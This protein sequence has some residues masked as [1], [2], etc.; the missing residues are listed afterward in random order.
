MS[1]ALSCAVLSLTSRRDLARSRAS[2]RAAL[3]SSGSSWAADATITAAAPCFP[4][5]SIA[6]G[7]WLAQQLQRRQSALPGQT[8]AGRREDGARPAYPQAPPVL[9]PTSWEKE[10]RSRGLEDDVPCGGETAQA[11]KYSYIRS[12]WS[13]LYRVN[14][15]V[16][17]TEQD[18][19]SVRVLVPSV[20]VCCLLCTVLRNVKCLRCVNSTYC[21]MLRPPWD[22]HR[23]AP[24]P[25]ST[26]YEYSDE[27]F[28]NGTGAA[29]RNIILRKF[30]CAC[31][32]QNPRGGSRG[33][34]PRQCP[35]KPFQV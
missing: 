4:A 35:H 6:I 20:L 34:A 26:P 18:M 31:R 9:S 27:S 3:G 16:R 30:A 19:P 1:R 10:S 13:L 15:L 32:P 7:Y 22:R 12:T 14:L 23:V 28:S 29:D 17:N 33:V 8:S 11:P 2:A 25:A 21:S 24:P 5:L